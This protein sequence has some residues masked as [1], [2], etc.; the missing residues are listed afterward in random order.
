MEGLK[1][2]SLCAL[3]FGIVIAFNQHV[4]LREGVRNFSRFSKRH[5]GEGGGGRE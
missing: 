4:T 3:H 2:M 1:G 5:A